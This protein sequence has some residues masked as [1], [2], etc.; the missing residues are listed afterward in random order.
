MSHPCVIYRK[1]A[2]PEVGGYPDIYPED[3]PLWALVLAKG[4]KFENLPDT[5]VKMRV[6]DAIS[7]RR[8][9]K[10]L[11]GEIKTFKLMHQAQLI[12]RYELYRNITQ[13]TL[14]RL[15]PNALKKAF[16][17]FLR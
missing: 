17:K 9:F 15:A 4:H 3:Y 16:Y 6:G 5:L 10:F 14:L 8:G 11:K 2:V 1:N 12:N 13:R 7:K